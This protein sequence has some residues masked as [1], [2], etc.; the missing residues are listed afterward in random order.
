M[1]RHSGFLVRCLPSQALRDERLR[2]HGLRLAR[3]EKVR[4]IGLAQQPKEQRRIVFRIHVV[5]E[6]ASQN[7]WTP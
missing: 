7:R 2:Q 5:H 3:P 4:P 1:M 6:T